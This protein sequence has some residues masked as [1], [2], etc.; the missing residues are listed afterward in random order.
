MHGI[1][2]CSATDGGRIAVNPRSFLSEETLTEV[3]LHP[4]EHT[5]S[6][7]VSPN[8][9]AFLLN[10]TLPVVNFWLILLH[11]TDEMPVK[12]TVLNVSFLNEEALAEC[13]VLTALNS[14]MLLQ[15]ID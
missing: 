10:L 5:G 9:C 15:S 14:E 6:M 7:A 8:N 2:E 12:L 11:P 4:V 3:H 1:E 13:S